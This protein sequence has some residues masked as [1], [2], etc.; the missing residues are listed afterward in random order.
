MH[1]LNVADGR[2]ANINLVGNCQML[3]LGDLNERAI[4]L[5]EVWEAVNETKSGK[6]PGLD[7]SPVEC[8]KE[9]CMAVLKWPVRLLNLVRCRGCTYGLA[10]C[11]YSAPVQR[12]G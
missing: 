6:V 1:I 7:G 4:S 9:C 5:E 10:W 12:E 2:E 8:L 11:L 3:V